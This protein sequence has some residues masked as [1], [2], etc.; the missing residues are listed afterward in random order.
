M[1]KHIASCLLLLVVLAV[2]AWAE[3]FLGLQL[4]PEGRTI[5]SSE[6][7]VEKVYN[8]PPEQVLEFFK[9]NLQGLKDIRFRE[10]GGN[11]IVEDFGTLPWNKVLIS[12]DKPNEAK[13]VVSKDSW[14]WI[15]GMLTLRFTGVFVVLIML[16]FATSIATGIL[17]RVLKDKP[18]EGK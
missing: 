12:K 7:S 6:E 4:P 18:L 8:L 16:Y 10:F 9:K 1:K 17:V 13:V 2:P 5:K 3:D 14:T 11:Y 15:L